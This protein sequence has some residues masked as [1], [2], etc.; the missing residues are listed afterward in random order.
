MNWTIVVA[1]AIAIVVTA[2]GGL[3][4]DVGPWYKNLRKPA[5]QPPDWL[6]GPAWTIILGLAAWAG[7]LAWQGAP[8]QAGR[9]RIAALF[10]VNLTLHVL[11]SPLFFVWRR[12]DWALIEMPFLWLSIIALMLGLEPFSPTA[13]RLLLPYISWVSFAFLLNLAV[14]RLNRPFGKTRLAGQ[15]A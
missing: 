5:W 2:A 4:T 13:S 3:M 1:A 14:V 11:W 8:D 10:A 12:P 15:G 9:M 6:F 7:V